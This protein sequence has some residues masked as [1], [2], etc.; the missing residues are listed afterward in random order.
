MYRC[1]C[2][3]GELYDLILTN[4]VNLTIM[5]L[6]AP[7]STNI[8]RCIWDYENN[9]DDYISGRIKASH[10]RSFAFFFLRFASLAAVVE[11][12]VRIR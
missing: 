3:L 2:S 12:F 8:K 9:S 1:P 6:G 5:D 7:N 11:R 10:W 4:V